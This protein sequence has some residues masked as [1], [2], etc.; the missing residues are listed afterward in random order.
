MYQGKSCGAIL[1]CWMGYFLLGFYVPTGRL[2]SKGLFPLFC[3][4]YLARLVILQNY[5]IYSYGI[6]IILRTGYNDSPSSYSYKMV[7][8]ILR[9]HTSHTN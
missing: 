5:V 6:L 3:Q 7:Q 9:H 2:Q 8:I 1:L 4:N